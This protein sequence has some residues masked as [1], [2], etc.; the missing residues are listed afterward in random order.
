MS[1]ST[2]TIQG[3]ISNCEKSLSEAIELCEQVA[4][5]HEYD[6]N[7]SLQSFKNELQMI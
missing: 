1:K 5:Q 4:G 2:S 7:F 3:Q 6:F